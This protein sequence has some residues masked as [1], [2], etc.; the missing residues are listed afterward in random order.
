MRTLQSSHAGVR[1]SYILSDTFANLARDR[2]QMSD[3]S[4]NDLTEPFW[5]GENGYAP[6][7]QDIVCPRD[8]RLG[9]A[10]V[11]TLPR[12]D[13]R[14]CTH[15]I[16]WTWQ[17][18]LSVVQDALDFWLSGPSVQLFALTDETFL[19]M[20]F[21]VNNQYRI[22]IE[23]TMSGSDNLQDVFAD[24]MMRIGRMVAL[25][26]TWDHP[27][28][29]TRI[30]TIFEQFS[31]SS[32]QIPMEFILPKTSAESLVAQLAKG[33][34]G[35]LRVRDS[36]CQIRSESARAS[37]PQDEQ[38]VKHLISEGIGFEAVDKF[39]KSSMLVW[40]SDRVHALMSRLVDEGEPPMNSEQFGLTSLP[41]NIVHM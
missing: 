11:D 19:Y 26:D 9:C 29:H 1:V 27:L 2:S 17:Y 18:K 13:R 41:P 14:L 21:F 20:C 35:I 34:P 15:F 10:M 39:I 23:G 32:L 6:I 31:A 37:H 16:S 3:P 38:I 30:W 12:D 25:L 40:V 28:Y 4:F 33:Q 36:V 8:G 22:L 7:G 24:H 5:K